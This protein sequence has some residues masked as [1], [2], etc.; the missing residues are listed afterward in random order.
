MLIG[1]ELLL[2]E[3]A[4]E[5]RPL[6]QSS[7]REF[8]TVLRGTCRPLVQG[9]CSALVAILKRGSCLLFCALRSLARGDSGSL[10]CEHEKHEAPSSLLNPITC[11]GAGAHGNARH[12]SECASAMIVGRWNDPARLQQSAILNC[13]LVGARLL[14][15]DARRTSRSLFEKICNSVKARI[16]GFFKPPRV[17]GSQLLDLHHKTVSE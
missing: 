1:S 17:N 4:W 5:A 6:A 3:E 13:M 9:L 2:R 16:P 7:S 10:V 12:S 15:C 8:P 11:T 14:I